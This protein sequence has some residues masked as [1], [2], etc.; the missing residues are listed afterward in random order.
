MLCKSC[1]VIELRPLRRAKNVIP[2]ELAVKMSK[3][4]G[5]KDESHGMISVAFVPK[6][7]AGFFLKFRPDSRIAIWMG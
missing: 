1:S 2:L 3:Q 4:R 6:V 7:Q 5:Y